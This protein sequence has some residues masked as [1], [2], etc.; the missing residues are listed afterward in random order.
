MGGA[1]AGDCKLCQSPEVGLQDQEE[2]WAW[3]LLVTT[4]WG[5]SEGPHRAPFINLV[6]SEDRL[7]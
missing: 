7:N 3:K 6:R 4:E 2:E 1:E 5:G